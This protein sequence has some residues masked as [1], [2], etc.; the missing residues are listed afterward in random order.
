MNKYILEEKLSHL[1][2]TQINLLIKRYY[3]G[4]K[5][6]GLLKEFQIQ[7]QPGKF[8]KYLPYVINQN[9][10][11]PSCNSQM[12]N[13]LEPRSGL[14]QIETIS[15]CTECNHRDV[16]YCNCDYC[17]KNES[18]LNASNETLIRGL[19]I[20]YCKTYETELK[21][22]SIFDLSFNEAMTILTLV[23]TCSLNEDGTYGSLRDSPFTF[24][25]KGNMWAEKLVHLIKKN[26]LRPADNS[27]ID[28][29][30][31]QDGAIN[32]F[33][34]VKVNWVFNCKNSQLLIMEIENCG[35]DGVWP[36][37]WYIEFNE[38]RYELA[39]AECL[40][41]YELCLNQRR[42]PY[43]N[44]AAVNKMLMNILRD[45]SVAQCYR[46]IWCG[47]TASSDFKLRN[48]V[49]SMHTMNYMVGACL[50]WADKARAEGW[51]VQPF[52]RNYNLPRS[53]LSHVLY[54]VMLKIGED[55]FNEPITKDYELYK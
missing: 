6:V 15:Q 19:I 5:I 50:R 47:A 7:C 38:L 41:Y 22:V 55:G 18:E 29:F 34:L 25:P 53:M 52:R 14:S 24:S 10:K 48:Q 37:M 35:L 51:P 36:V 39:I 43:K 30:T 28:A 17:K 21:G 44:S 13:K 42:L 45:H 8:H 11:C 12:A 9:K 33:E 1:S 20:D 49:N 4:E 46:I 23:R 3:K 26:L 32:S 40:E 54:D 2:E 27:D 16:Q 31:F